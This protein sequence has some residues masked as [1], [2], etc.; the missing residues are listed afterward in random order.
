MVAAVLVAAALT[1]G[2]TRSDEAPH[3]G[4]FA[5]PTPTSAGCDTG[6]GRSLTALGATPLDWAAHHVATYE[7]VSAPQTRWDAR[8]DLP[9]FRGHEGAVY[10]DT[11][12]YNNCVTGT[13]YVQLPRPVDTSVALRR[14][15][16]EL[17]GDALIFWRG[18]RSRCTQ[19]GVSSAQLVAALQ[20]RDRYPDSTI[21]LVELPHRP[22]A[23][24]T[25]RIGLSIVLRREL[26]HTR[27]WVNG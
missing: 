21:V 16:R 1:I 15:L 12:F 24:V 23:R 18:K 3:H 5:S 22:G 19:Y 10:N 4:A 25:D 26:A 2:L 6:K 20:A 7:P 13:Y 11:R 8:V 17:P 14:G 9:R 27:C